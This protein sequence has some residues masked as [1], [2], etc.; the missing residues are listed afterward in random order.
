MF[1]IHRKLFLALKKVRIIKITSHQV[2]FIQQ[3]NLPPPPSKISDSPPPP[4]PPYH[5]LE[6][7]VIGQYIFQL[8][9]T[10]F[11]SANPQAQPA[12]ICSIQQH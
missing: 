5:Y 6:N 1:S 3:K 7:P 10:N 9:V 2:P 11:Q 8:L 12:F 4:P